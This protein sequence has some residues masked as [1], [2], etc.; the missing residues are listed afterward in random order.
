MWSYQYYHIPEHRPAPPKATRYSGMFTWHCY[1]QSTAIVGYGDLWI[2]INGTCLVYNNITRY[3]DSD[4]SPVRDV[5]TLVLSC[6]PDPSG[7]GRGGGKRVFPSWGVWRA[8][9]NW[10]A[11]P[12]LIYTARLQVHFH[13]AWLLSCK[14]Q[15]V[16]T[17]WM[18]LHRWLQGCQSK[19]ALGHSKSLSFSSSPSDFC[20]HQFFFHCQLHWKPHG[21]DLIC[22]GLIMDHDI[23]L[24]ALYHPWYYWA[25]KDFPF[26][27]WPY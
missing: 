15:N 16:F 6:A 1:K 14:L 8:R 20:L 10:E 27:T 4:W 22:N 23:A 17:P 9:L 12:T 11:M 19:C 24:P 2:I 3:T 26:A 5:T 21:R 18:K 13:P 25:A 7:R